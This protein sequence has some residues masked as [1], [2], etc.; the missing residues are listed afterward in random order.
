MKK[1]V[2]I[3]CLSVL[4]S[5]CF[6][7]EYNVGSGSNKGVEETGKNHYIIFGLAPL[8]TVQPADL[9]KGATDYKVRHEHT[10]VDGLLRVITF[11]L[12]TP[13]TTTVTR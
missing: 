6:V 2:L 4:V 8:S 5:S 12:Y 13:T 7:Q 9:A 3:F 11:G 10:F 1:H